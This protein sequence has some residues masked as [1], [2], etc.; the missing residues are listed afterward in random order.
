MGVPRLVHVSTE[1]VLVGGRPIVNADETWP[2]PARPIGLYP[3][4]KGLAE[5]RV[6]AANS[7]ELCTLIVRPRFIWGKGDTTLLPRIIE[8]VRRGQFRWIGGGR[9]LTSTCHVRNA[10]EGMILAAEHG[11]GGEIYFLTDGPPV[12]MRAFLTDLLATQGV[13]PGAR[14]IPLWLACT[15][16]LVSE[17]TYSLLRIRRPPPA[18]RTAV[19]LIGREITVNDAKAR[20]QLGYVG[21]VTRIAGLEEMR[22][23]PM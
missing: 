22:T 19:E 14:S 10:C 9:H 5:E 17:K 20:S 13:D 1:A 12:E 6:L 3:L 8:A 18:S 2:R 11:R 21:W 15:V 23:A 16:A 4:T 7:P